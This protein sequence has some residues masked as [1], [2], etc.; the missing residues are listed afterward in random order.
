MLWRSADIY[1]G[2][3]KFLAQW[4]PK[5]GHRNQRS[6]TRRST[7]STR[8]AIRPNTK[9]LYLESPTNPTLRVVDFKK[10]AELAKQK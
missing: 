6:S 1:G 3:N 10:V 8:R 4:L 9:L 5:M 2:V 7:S